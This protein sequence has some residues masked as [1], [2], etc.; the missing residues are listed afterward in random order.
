MANYLLLNKSS[1]NTLEDI[2][3]KNL[4][5]LLLGF[6]ATLSFA[7]DYQTYLQKGE[8]L[9]IGDRLLGMMN[10][11]NYGSYLILQGDG[12][13]VLYNYVSSDGETDAIPSWSSQ[14]NSGAYAVM[15]GDG[16]F[17][18]Y[19]DNQYPVWSTNTFADEGNINSANVFLGGIN[20]L[21]VY[22]WYHH[23]DSPGD[24][25]AAHPGHV[26]GVVEKDLRTLFN[27]K[28]DSNIIIQDNGFAM[29]QVYGKRKIVKKKLKVVAFDILMEY[30]SGDKFSRDI[31]E[32]E[33]VVGPRDSIDKFRIEHSSSERDQM[34]LAAH[35]PGD[36]DSPE[37][38]ELR[39]KD[40]QSSDDGIPEGD[41][42]VQEA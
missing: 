25:W 15:Q 7:R 30:I 35:K 5:I 34:R 3:M 21:E 29:V 41:E 10:T 6:T 24:V 42:G 11:D 36:H 16:N 19:D 20:H 32:F 33:G 17:V 40:G 37:M 27:F 14:T 2:L 12:N 28:N 26:G 13:L 39:E 9:H 18:L 22:H 8:V 4:I 38:N 1:I 31:V 23:G